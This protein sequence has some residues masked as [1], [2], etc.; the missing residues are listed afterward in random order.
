MFYFLLRN[1]SVPRGEDFF[2]FH[3]LNTKFEI[4]R[5][6]AVLSW[7]TGLC[8]IYPD[9]GITTQLYVGIP[10]LGLPTLTKP[11][12]SSSY[13]PYPVR[14]E[15]AL[16]TAL[17]IRKLGNSIHSFCLQDRIPLS[18]PRAR[19]WESHTL[20]LSP[21]KARNWALELL[22]LLLHNNQVLPK[23]S[24]PE[25]STSSHH[26]CFYS[27]EQVHQLKLGHV[28]NLSWKEIWDIWALVFQPLACRK[29]I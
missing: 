1:P 12:T 5:F 13:V 3:L 21:H 8:F 17:R 24:L 20:P 25:V 27:I 26:F 9:A 10:P 7:A 16:R 2:R 22:K 23:T 11:W 6:P 14:H 4:G 18:W 29:G 15:M 19:K 28:W